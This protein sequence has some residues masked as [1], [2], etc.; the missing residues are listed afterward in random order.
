MIDTCLRN[1]YCLY[2]LKTN[3]TISIVK[4]QLKLINQIL[5]KYQKERSRHSIT[6]ENNHSSRFN[7]RHF[8]SLYEAKEGKNRL[9]RCVRKTIE[10][11]V[12]NIKNVMLGC[13]CF[14][15]SKFKY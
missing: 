13:A 15:V 12:I 6:P 9:R 1:L 14:H 7:G 3:K 5:K 2:K 10:N 8:P 4:F 11:L